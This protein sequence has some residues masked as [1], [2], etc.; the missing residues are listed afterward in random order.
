M[1]RDFDF[2]PTNDPLIRA[3]SV[4]MSYE[5][6]SFMNTFI[7]TLIE[8]LTQYGIKIPRI[9][10][11]QRDSLQNV[12]NGQVIYNTTIDEF[13]GRRAGVWVNL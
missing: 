12:E 2:F 5:W 9:T 4:Y 3:G 6:S 11:A 13:Q 8:Y 10:T 1:S 7:E